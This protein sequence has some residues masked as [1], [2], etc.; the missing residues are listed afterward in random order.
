[1]DHQIESIKNLFHDI[2]E[3]L[4]E[5]LFLDLL[6]TETFRVERIVSRGHS[7]PEGLWYDQEDGEWI[8]LLK[9][10]AGLRFADTPET[11]TLGPGDYLHIPPHVQH[12]VDWTAKDQDTVWLAIHYREKP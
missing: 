6:V 3:E 12:R 9:G 10:A 8:I 4:Q 11:M 7:S 2:P 1:M 5:E